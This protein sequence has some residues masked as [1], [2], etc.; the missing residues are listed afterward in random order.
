MLFV[1]GRSGAKDPRRLRTESAHVIGSR[2]ALLV[3]GAIVKP[4]LKKLVG[5][6]AKAKKKSA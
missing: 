5:A 4:N 1:W 3:W 2:V 6:G